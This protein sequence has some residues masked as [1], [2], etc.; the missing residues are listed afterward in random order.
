MKHPRLGQRAVTTC[1]SRSGRLAISV[2][3]GYS[4]S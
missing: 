3:Q 2:W 1:P 4:I